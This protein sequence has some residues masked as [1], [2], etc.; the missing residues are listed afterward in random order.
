[1]LTPYTYTVSKVREGADMRRMGLTFM[2]VAVMVALSA[3]V[4]LAVVKYG[5]EGND[6]IR[7]TDDSDVLYGKGGA[8]F[9]EGLADDD[10]LHGGEGRDLLGD[11]TGDD[12][13]YGGGGSDEIFSFPGNDIIHGGDGGDLIFE[14]RGNNILYGGGGDDFIQATAIN[15][16]RPGS[17]DRTPRERDLIFCGSGRDVVAVDP[18]N[19]DFVAPDCEKVL[20]RTGHGDI[21]L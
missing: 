21:G 9:I 16:D 11:Q 1:M 13:L 12:K 20:I 8:D 2:V 19:V 7:G 15:P 10:V 14:G 6:S 3:S 18:G 5:T 4:A 17:E